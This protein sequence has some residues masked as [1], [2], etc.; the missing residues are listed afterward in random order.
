MVNVQD[1]ISAFNELGVNQ[2][3]LKDYCATEGKGLNRFGLIIA[4]G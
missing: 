3:E 2:D 1:A 4:E